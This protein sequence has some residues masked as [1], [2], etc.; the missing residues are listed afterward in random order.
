MYESNFKSIAD[1]GF[2]LGFQKGVLKLQL[3]LFKAMEVENSSTISYKSIMK[4]SN[5]LIKSQNNDK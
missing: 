4:I 3:E 2:S 1:K 5:L